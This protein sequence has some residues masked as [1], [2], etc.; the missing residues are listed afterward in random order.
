[1]LYT[2]TIYGWIVQNVFD[3]YGFFYLNYLLLLYIH[4]LLNNELEFVKAKS[5]VMDYLKWL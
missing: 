2:A 3:F 5:I 1:M 4:F